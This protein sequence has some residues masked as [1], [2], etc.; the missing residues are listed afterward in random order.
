[1]KFKAAAF[2]CIGV[3]LG[4][5]IT[6]ASTR[7]TKYSGDVL[8]CTDKVSGKTRLTISGECDESIE[9]TELVTDLWGLQ[10]STSAPP[11]TTPTTTRVL[12]KYVVDRSGKTVGEL[13]SN[14]GV[15]NFWV[16]FEGGN[17]NVSAGGFTYANG[18][19]GDPTVFSDSRCQLP[20]LIPQSGIDVSSLRL[21]VDVPATSRPT[22]KK[23]RKAF[24][25]VGV[26]IST[27]QKI[28]VY[29]T[30]KDAQY[31]I[32]YYGTRDSVPEE[33]LWKTKKGCV[34]ITHDEYERFNSFQ[35]APRVYRTVTTRL[36]TYSPPLSVIEK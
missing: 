17:Y 21:V 20:F 16:L 13:I 30:P 12:K 9:S 27:P 29:N 33:R 6:L 26:E 7:S 25:A 28:Y 10:P 24:R 19:S 31:W 32:D 4:S 2:L 36:P 18:W 11:A 23:V 22:N 34:S 8:A 3:L 1:M 15:Q 14:D 35:V 5:T